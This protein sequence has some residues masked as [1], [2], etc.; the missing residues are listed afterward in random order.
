MFIQSFPLQKESQSLEQTSNSRGHMRLHKERTLSQLLQTF[1][2]VT[3]M[4]LILWYKATPI[5]YE[6]PT[7]AVQNYLR[8][9][10]CFA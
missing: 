7:P 1:T 6:C 8:Q 10:H 4:T 3:N 9:V 5:T 2:A